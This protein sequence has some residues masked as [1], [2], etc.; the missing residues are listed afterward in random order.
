MSV[1]RR[2][3]FTDL[4]GPS[5]SSNN[6]LEKTSNISQMERKLEKFLQDDGGNTSG[7]RTDAEAVSKNHHDESNHSNGHNKHVLS[8]ESDN[9]DETDTHTDAESTDFSDPS[10]DFAALAARTN[11]ELTETLSNVHGQVSQLTSAVQNLSSQVTKLSNS[12]LNRSGEISEPAEQKVLQ[13]L[14][15]LTE[16]EEQYQQSSQKLW[17]R[18]LAQLNQTVA[19]MNNNAASVVPVGPLQYLRTGWR[20]RILVV[21]IC[22]WPFV[23]YK[24]WGAFKL[25]IC[26]HGEPG[27]FLHRIAV[28]IF[29]GTGFTKQLARQ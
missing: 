28:M 12:P 15:R 14:K 20:G 19:S 1:K 2:L 17:E 25:W 27:S 29:G 6:S 7:I 23:S 3:E 5:T 18:R 16:L 24:L 10:N 4:I 26:T 21:L 13:Q 8:D 11:V 22:V 9:D